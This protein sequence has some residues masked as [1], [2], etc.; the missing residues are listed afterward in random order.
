MPV[1]SLC[2]RWFCFWQGSLLPDSFEVS[3]ISE[4]EEHKVLVLS[5]K[6]V[7]YPMDS[8]LSRGPFF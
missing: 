5:T 4:V 8:V 2:S 7:F 3:V 6:E 1:G